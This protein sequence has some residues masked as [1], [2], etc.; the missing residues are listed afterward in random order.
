MQVSREKAIL[1]FEGVTIFLI[2]ALFI[3]E[4]PLFINVIL[5]I[6]Y[7]DKIV[8]GRKVKIKGAHDMYFVQVSSI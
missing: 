2:S 7:N 4:Y 3:E 1:A 5:F 6:Y 8:F